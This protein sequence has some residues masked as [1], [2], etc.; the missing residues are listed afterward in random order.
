MTDQ[1]DIQSLLFRHS[2]RNDLYRKV[3]QK[4][5]CTAFAVTIATIDIVH[6]VHIVHI[7]INVIKY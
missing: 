2:I 1:K 5:K 4:N 3:C 7:V 6:I